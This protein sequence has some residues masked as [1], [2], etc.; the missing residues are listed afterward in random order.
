M[1]KQPFKCLSDNL[2]RL[3]SLSLPLQGMFSNPFVF[4]LLSSEPFPI[5]QQ[6][7]L[8]LWTQFFQTDCIHAKDR[9][10]TTILYISLV[11]YLWV[12][13]YSWLPACTHSSSQM[14]I[15]STGFFRLTSACLQDPYLA[16]VTHSLCYWRLMFVW[17]KIYGLL[18]CS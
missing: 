6:P 3:S 9:G 8:E 13:S 1:I 17:T 16:A 14:I 18:N 10:N 4:S 7:S 2:N 5:F 11:M 15:C 12:V